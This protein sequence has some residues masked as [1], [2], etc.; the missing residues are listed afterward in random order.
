MEVDL[1]DFQNFKIVTFLHLLLV[2]LC[3]Y[4]PQEVDISTETQGVL[5]EKSILDIFRDL[6][7]MLVKGVWAAL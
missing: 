2:V 3:V 5:R 7:I 6:H 1:G 4:S